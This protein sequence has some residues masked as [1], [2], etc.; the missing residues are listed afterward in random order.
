MV[1]V[2]HKRNNA[3]QLAASSSSAGA[4]TADRVQHKVHNTLCISLTQHINALGLPDNAQSWGGW[5]LAACANTTLQ[6][7]R[8]HNNAQHQTL[9]GG[10]QSCVKMMRYYK[11]WVFLL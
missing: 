1:R 9:P 7:S 3:Q 2:N 6:A 4:E 11:F 8:K 10:L 5:D